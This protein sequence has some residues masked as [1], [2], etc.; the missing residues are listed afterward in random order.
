MD[1][2]R[3][4]IVF[5]RNLTPEWYIKCAKQWQKGSKNVPIINIAEPRTLFPSEIANIVNTVWKRNGELATQG[6]SSVKSLHYYQGIELL[7]DEESEFKALQYLSIL[8]KNSCGLFSFCGNQSHRKIPQKKPKK[9]FSK[10]GKTLSNY[11]SLFGLL[12]YK[13][14]YKKEDYMGSAAY[15]AGQLLKVADRLHFM[16]CRIKRDGEIPPQLAGNAMFVT[17]L[18]TPSKALVTLEQ[19]MMPYIG[20]AEQYSEEGPEYDPNDGELKKNKGKSKQRAAYYLNLYGDIDLELK[21]TPFVSMQTPNQ[22]FNDAEKLQFSIGYLAAFP[23]IEPRDGEVLD[24][25]DGW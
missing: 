2:S 9:Q 4:K 24:E 5:T 19:R 3:S 8:L 15:Q 16:Y 1:K 12:L 18:E 20:W 11:W 23:K 25:D 13:S 21:D 14:G 17:A 22:R 10:A 7:I 6:K